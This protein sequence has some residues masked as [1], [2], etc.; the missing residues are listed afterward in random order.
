MNTM[1]LVLREQMQNIYWHTSY[2]FPT[3]IIMEWNHSYSFTYEKF[4]V[5]PLWFW[6]WW[7][8]TLK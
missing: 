3:A 1:A 7:Q 4:F 8:E 5:Y 2:G 6:H